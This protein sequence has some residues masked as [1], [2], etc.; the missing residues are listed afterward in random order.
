MSA[1]P[2][3]LIK[4]GT[5]SL[6]DNG[7]LSPS[8]FSTVASQIH[9]L[10]SHRIAIISSGGIQAGKEYLGRNAKDWQAFDNYQLAGFGAKDL[11]NHW[12]SALGVIG[13]LVAQAYFSSQDLDSRS[14]LYHIRHCLEGILAAGDIA[15]INNNDMANRKEIDLMAENRSE[16]DELTADTAEALQPEMVAIVTDAGGVFDRDP[17]GRG[18]KLIEQ[19]SWSRYQELLEA[20]QTDSGN[21]VRSGGI[22]KK[23]EAAF[24]CHRTGARVGIIPLDDIHRFAIGRPVGTL[25]VD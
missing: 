15:I 18:A 7:Q 1:K 16:N 21:D 6:M 11:I 24:R 17:Q 5:K 12:D 20:G 8:S 2:T 23:L 19:L 25:I 10:P 9:A 3:M 14:C 13:R 22:G 4:I